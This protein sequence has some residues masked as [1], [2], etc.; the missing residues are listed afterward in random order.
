MKFNFKSIRE[1]IV[2]FL[3]AIIIFIYLFFITRN[4]EN[5]VERLLLSL[6]MSIV[7]QS[8]GFIAYVISE[9]IVE[10]VAGYKIPKL[11][12]NIFSTQAVVAV[13]LASV[14]WIMWQYSITKQLNDLGDCLNESKSM[15]NEFSKPSEFLAWCDEN[16]SSVDTYSE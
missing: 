5:F 6:L 3:P 11:S 7:I 9:A 2:L 14:V 8:V 16:M 12:G 10:Y 1:G 4:D 13:L 15:A